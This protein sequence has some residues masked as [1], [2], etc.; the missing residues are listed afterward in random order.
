MDEPTLNRRSLLQTTGG[1]AGAAALGLLGTGSAAADEGAIETA[2]GVTEPQFELGEPEEIYVDV[3]MTFEN[4]DGE[5]VTETPTL[6][7]EVVRPVCS[8]S[9]QPMDDTPVILTYTPYGD[10]YQ[11]LNDGESPA[12]D[13][14]AEYFVPRGYARVMVDLIGCRNSDGYYDYGG[15]RERLSGK[16]LVEA[17]AHGEGFEWTNGRVGMIGGSYD[18]TTQ[19][20]AAVENPDGLEAIIPQVAIDRWYDYRHFGGCPRSTVGTPTLFN[21]GF[22]AVPPRA[23]DPAHNVDVT[24]TRVEPSRRAE[25]EQRSYEYEPEYDEFWEERDYRTK[26][27]DVDCAVMI[28]AG[29]EDRNV[30]RWGSTRFYEALKEAGHDDRRL[31]MGDWGHA[32][33]QYPDTQDLYHAFYDKHLLSGDEG[34]LRETPETGVMDLP[35]VDVQSEASPRTQFSEWPPEDADEVVLPLVRNDASQGEL[36]LLGSVASWEDGSPPPEE[37]DFFDER[38]SGDDHLMFETPSLDEEIRF[39]GRVTADLLA[40]S[41]DDTWYTV[42]VY[43]RD[44]DEVRPF[45]RGAWNSRFRNDLGEPESTPETDA[46]R[47]GVEAWDINWTVSA[48]NRL[49]VIVASDND[50]YVRHDPTNASTNQL[51]LGDSVLCFDGFAEGIET[52]SFPTVDLS[53]DI[54]RHNSVSVAGEEVEGSVHA[55]GWTARCTVTVDSATDETR[56]RLPIPDGWTVLA[57]DD[58]E[59]REVSAGDTS[60]T[61]VEFDR[62]VEEGD[63]LELF[64][65]APGE[66]GEY[67]FG[68]VEY[69]SAAGDLWAAEGDTAETAVVVGLETS[70]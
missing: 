60:T 42:V 49:G 37:D 26:A 64:L 44:G 36:E 1:L 40:A 50:D 70:F 55:A 62:T 38:A 61:F 51:V 46:Y 57:G 11:P 4:A 39:T 8:C 16:E 68:P 33:G 65:E 53:R 45:A 69:S 3:E 29:W 34:W 25:F 52:P 58:F 23:G 13:G 21:W 31:V 47:I 20:A 56:V 30:I 32:S 28:E 6:Y 22:A 15:I 14:I 24:A 59:E 9:G 5:E 63:E 19:F 10:L 54:D 2:G 67:E 7:G 41:T 12:K 18:G 35:R 48:G 27:D 17:L 43:E 66:T